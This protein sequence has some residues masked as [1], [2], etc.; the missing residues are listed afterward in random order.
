M[1]F[2]YLIPTKIYFGRSIIEREKD[3]LLGLCSKGLK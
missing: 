2:N 1:E 3:A